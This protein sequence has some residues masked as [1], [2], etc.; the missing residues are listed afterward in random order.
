MDKGN[1]TKR[2]GIV[3]LYD[4]NFGTCLQAFALFIKIKECGYNPQIIRYSRSDKPVCL[5]NNIGLKLQKLRNISLKVLFNYLISYRKIKD[6]K[7]GFSTFRKEY[8]SFTQENNYRDSISGNTINGFDGYVCGSDM[9]WSEEFVDDWNYFYLNFA[10]KG[11]RVAYAPSFGK[12]EISNKNRPLCRKL[13][14]GI[15]CIS[16]RE[17]GGTAM[18]KQY[19][20]LDVQQ[21]L[22]PTLLLTKD[23]WNF[24]LKNDHPIIDEKYTLTYVFGGL[25][26]AR[27]GIFSQI[28]NKNW[29]I[30]K[31]IPMNR[32]QYNKHSINGVLGPA[33]FIN[34]YSNAEFI[35]TDTFH[36]LIFALIYE[37]PFV[38][39]KREDGSHWAKYSDRMT[40]ML[41]ML[42]LEDRYIDSKAIIPDRFKYLDYGQI[43]KKVEMKRSESFFYLK[44]SLD[45]VMSQNA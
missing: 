6:R 13:L 42:G 31:V 24:V 33:E 44:D 20:D 34:L 26:G 32:Y 30:H 4:D 22:D 5:G 43:N 8:L 11:K 29:G 38:V 37:K 7:E 16:C 2:C 39:L 23:E 36:G 3:T 19:Y 18:L 21:V 14:E 45:K 25:N 12:N 40:S 41:S 10:P 15:D 27:E 9:I 35:I 17:V 1:V 28:K